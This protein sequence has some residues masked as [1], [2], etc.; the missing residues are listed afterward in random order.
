M[1][2]DNPESFRLL[3]QWLLTGDV[4]HLHPEAATL[5]C[6]EYGGLRVGSQ[7]L[8]IQSMFFLCKMCMLDAQLDIE[9]AIISGYKN[10][11]NTEAAMTPELLE[12]IYLHQPSPRKGLR[13][14]SGNLADSWACRQAMIQILEGGTN[15]E[16][17]ARLMKEDESCDEL[18]TPCLWSLW[19]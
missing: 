2:E 1:P 11:I 7:V 9:Q 19:E 5:A 12:L 13:S 10:M 17:Y 6:Q 16:A 3:V 18:L 8:F 15:P 14:R 4:N